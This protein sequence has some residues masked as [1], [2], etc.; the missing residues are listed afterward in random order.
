M[1][2]AFFFLLSISTLLLFFRCDAD[3]DMDR[4]TK[5]LACIRLVRAGL[6]HD[7]NYFKYVA[8][9]I[10]TNNADDLIRR[11]I[12]KTL[13]SCFNTISM[14]KSAELIGKKTHANVS[15]FQ[16]ENQRILKIE[17][18]REKY[19]N[20]AS[21]LQ[22]DTQ[23]LDLALTDLQTDLKGLTDAV[24]ILAKEFVMKFKQEEMERERRQRQQ[25]AEYEPE[26]WYENKNLNLGLV[27]KIDPEIKNLIGLGLITLIAL[28]LLLGYRALRKSPTN[29]TPKKKQ[30]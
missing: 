24:A 29:T 2:I 17:S 28:S 7:D 9:S 20:D 23:K 30:K 25:E 14:L 3:A 8:Y 12:N 1:K 5:A 13:L 22:R 4:R 16:Q 26:G 18:F 11:W 15:P 21:R 10:N 27:T 6:L 19:E